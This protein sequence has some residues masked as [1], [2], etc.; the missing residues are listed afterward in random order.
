VA[1]T[2][3]APA[4]LTKVS[5]AAALADEMKLTQD[6]AYEMV[7]TLCEIIAK[8]V[9]QG[10]SVSISNFM[11]WERVVRAPRLVRNPRTEKMVHVP[12]RK[13]VKV[14]ISPRLTAFANSADPSQT[15]IKKSSGRS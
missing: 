14:N 9:A 10:G 2:K 8:T 11:S 1:E 3:T 15:T 5:L 12:E 4:N 7:M 6:V 13:A